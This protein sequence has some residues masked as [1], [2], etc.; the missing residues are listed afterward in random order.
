V[1]GEAVKDGCCQREFRCK[2]LSLLARRSA[3]EAHARTAVPDTCPL[4]EVVLAATPKGALWLGDVNSYSSRAAPL[5]AAQPYPRHGQE[6]HHDCTR[7]V[8]S[9]RIRVRADVCPSATADIELSVPH[10]P[11]GELAVYTAA[12]EARASASRLC[13]QPH[14]GCCPRLHA[15]DGR[16]HEKARGLEGIVS[17]HAHTLPT[18]CG[19]R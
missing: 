13:S 15:A 11:S 6:C 1:K 2:W 19:D 3:A 14:S 18:D 16:R 17:K 8:G 12:F 10:S 5:Y 7:Q 4:F 9:Y